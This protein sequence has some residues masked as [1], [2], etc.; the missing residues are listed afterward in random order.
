MAILMDY[1]R[2]ANAAF[3]VLNDRNRVQ[4]QGVIHNLSDAMMVKVCINMNN[5]L[6][7]ASICAETRVVDIGER[8]SRIITGRR[9]DLRYYRRKYELPTFRHLIR[10]SAIDPAHPS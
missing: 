1:F 10:L 6:F 5:D 7:I 3:T 8:G 4:S 9:T 2:S